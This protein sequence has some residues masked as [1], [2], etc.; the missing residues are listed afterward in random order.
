MQVFAVIYMFTKC[1]QIQQTCA[2]SWWRWMESS[3]KG[4]EK[5][6]Q[7]QARSKRGETLKRLN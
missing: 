3:T 6:R 1:K 4:G 7:G 2:K 5:K